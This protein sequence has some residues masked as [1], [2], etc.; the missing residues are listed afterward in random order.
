MLPLL[1]DA[2]LSTP[3]DVIV[4]VVDLAGV[5]ANAMLGGLA[6]RAA[7]LDI[8]GFV[9][10]AIASG[11]GGGIIRDLLLGTGPVLA[12]T[13]PLYL[14]FSVVGALLVAIIPFSSPRAAT[15]LAV[16]DASALGCWAAVGTQRGL[17][18]GLDW[19]PAILLGVVTAVGGGMVR[20]LLLVR[21]PA[22]LGGNTLYATSALA[23]AVFVVVFSAVGL[24]I[25]GTFSSLVVAAAL[26]LLAR[27]YRWTLPL[28]PMLRVGHRSQ[29]SPRT[30]TIQVR[31]TSI[32]VVGKRSDGGG[33][34][35]H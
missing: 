5:F 25:V 10:L 11:L 19:L 2:A 8:F 17:N 23:G 22:V 35:G 33:D 21:R 34:R 6:A 31:T 13:D 30:T 20:D 9:V 28:A 3:A 32:P 1:T 7:R 29:R 18:A 24:P 15:G 4:R 16:V 27:H 12:L 14:W 26:S